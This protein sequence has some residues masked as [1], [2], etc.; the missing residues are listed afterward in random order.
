MISIDVR[1][2]YVDFPIFDA[3]TRSLK[4]RV[5][6]KVGGKIGTESR[7]PIIEALHDI[8]LSL[9]SGDRVALVGHNGAG[10]S[11]LLRLL[12][13]IYEPTRGF[14]RVRGRVAPVFDLGVGMDQEIS[15]YENILIRGL[16]LGMSRKEMEKRID[17]IADFTELG[18]YLS[19]PLRTYSTGMRVRLA[20]GVV[21][22]IDPEILLLDEG[23]GAVD[24]AFLNKARDRL[25]DL[26]KRSGLLVFASHQDDL[27]LELCT[28]A[29]WMDEGRMKMQGSLREVLTAYKGRDPFENMS[30]EALQR[31]EESSAASSA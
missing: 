7:V 18:D 17:D 23:I 4:K 9:K 16:Y 11:T 13:G 21:T 20:L 25:V 10:K 6:G 26:V 22:S 30:P 24:A 14:A 5:L 31:L 3:K 8:N 2:A 15:G 1:N 19:M 12:S 27:L 28:S 29:I